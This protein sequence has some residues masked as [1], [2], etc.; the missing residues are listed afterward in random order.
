MASWV[1]E[2]LARACVRAAAGRGRDSARSGRDFLPKRTRSVRRRRRALSA[3]VRR[4]WSN[5][6]RTFVLRDRDRRDPDR[7]DPMAHTRGAREE[8]ALRFV[9][10]ADATS[11]RRALSRR[12]EE[13]REHL[14][15]RVA[16]PA[17]RIVR[18]REAVRDLAV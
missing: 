7:P 3:L 14:R 5:Y 6:L 8:A 15:A 18:G 2:S 11:V 17:L 1:R 9:R 12:H 16:G 10:H 4:R 13:P